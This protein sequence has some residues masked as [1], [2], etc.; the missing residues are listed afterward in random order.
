MANVDPGRYANQ[1]E[2]L[3]QPPTEYRGPRP[4]KGKRKGIRDLVKLLMGR[5]AANGR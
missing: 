5:R 2:A 1:R 3:R 4:P